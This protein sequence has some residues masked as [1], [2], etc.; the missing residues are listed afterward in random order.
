WTAL[1][2]GLARSLNGRL[3]L[4]VRVQGRTA[5]RAAHLQRSL[6]REKMVT[7]VEGFS[8]RRADLV[9]PMGR[10]TEDLARM[11]GAPPEQMLLLPFPLSWGEEGPSEVEHAERSRKEPHLIACA[12]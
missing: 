12:T 10:Y 1:G 6:L 11:L 8:V 2:A 5:T 9:V 7:A 4:A 3:F